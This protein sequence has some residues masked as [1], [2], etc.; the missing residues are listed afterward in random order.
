[1]YICTC[2]SGLENGLGYI[3]SELVTLCLALTRI[4]AILNQ[5]NISI[6]QL[7]QIWYIPLESFSSVKSSLCS[8]KIFIAENLWFLSWS[9]SPSRTTFHFDLPSD[10]HRIFTLLTKG[11]G[12]PC[13]ISKGFPFLRWVALQEI[14]VCTDLTGNCNNNTSKPSLSM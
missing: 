5:R 7:C 12:K 13:W 4:I 1:M 14:E 6:W 3:S 9:P 10:I 8:W 11:I 2:S